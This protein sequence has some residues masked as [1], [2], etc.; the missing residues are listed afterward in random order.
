MYGKEVAGKSTAKFKVGDKVR[1]NETRRAFDKSYLPNWTKEIFTVT[2]VIDI[3][4]PTYKLE[5][6]GHTKIEGNFYEKEIQRVVKTD[7]ILKIEKVLSARKRKGIKEYF[8]KIQ[9][10]DWRIGLDDEYSSFLVLSR[11]SLAIWNVTTSNLT[12]SSPPTRTTR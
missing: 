9:F 7:D 8:E 11:S 10:V 12:K 4:P 2:E 6:Y 3:K 1:I 5:G